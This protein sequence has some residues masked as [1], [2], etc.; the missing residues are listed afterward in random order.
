M[1]SATIE[2]DILVVGGA[3]AGLRAA[4]EVAEYNLRT[5]L[6]SKGPIARSGATLLA[7]ADFTLD[8]KSLNELGFPGEPRDTKEKFF[9]DILTQGF[10]LNNQKLVEL[11]VQE[12]P[13]RIKELLDWGVKVKFSEERAIFTSGPSVLNALLRQAKRCGVELIDDTMLLDLL[14]NDKKVAGALC[15]NL[16]TGEF[17]PYRSKAVILAN[18]GWHKAFSFNAG[19]RE[20]SGDGQAAAYRAGAQLSNMEFITFCPNTIL[21]PP[22]WRGCIFLYVVH[23]LVGG[24]LVN[25]KG[26]DF[27]KNY[28]IEVVKVGT[29]TE[30]NKCFL[31]PICASQVQEGKGSPSGGVYFEIEGEDFADR[32]QQR[33]PNWKYKGIDFSELIKNLN[34]GGSIE[35]G[36]AA[37]YFEGGIYVNEYFETSL[38]GLYAAGEC[39]VS[40]F[41]ANRVAAATTEM[42]VEGAIAG[43]TAAEYA[44]KISFPLLN[45]KQLEKLQTQALEPIQ[46]KNGLKPSDLMNEA[47]EMA[48]QKLGPIRN[49]QG[50]EKI[51]SHLSEVKHSKLTQLYID[52]KSRKY[53]KGWLQAI[54]LRNIIQLLEIS[55]KSALVRTESRGVHYRSDH[56]YTDNDRWLIET[57]VALIDNEP[58]MSSHPV[59]ST[60]LTPPKGQIPY[61][62][63]LKHM[64]QSHSEIGGHH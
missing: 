24:R 38:K 50:L 35:V 51:D 10:Y 17:I 19:T 54:E 39:A 48:Y 27:L 56:P 15:L 22:I 7:G 37:E 11:Y 40:L 28:D 60:R 33:Y 43:K 55:V 13:N 52:S 41:G 47:Q 3:G 23:L 18:G 1:S 8:G 16:K 44:K 57:H 6:I 59:L 12:A 45:E 62:D 29:S 25:N 9:N 36:P 46:H 58:Q 30:W 42:L 32:V 31:S 2:T 4:I 20:L 49:R 34:E 53:N 61:I 64:M 63:M 14:T 21:A 5:T 26:E